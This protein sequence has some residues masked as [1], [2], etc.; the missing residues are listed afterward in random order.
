MYGL[1]GLFG[2]GVYSFCKDYTQVQYDQSVDK[3][4]SEKNPIFVEGGKEFYEK[5]VS[6]NIAL[7]KLMGRFGEKQYSALGNEN[8][9][10]R[11]KCLPLVTRKSFFEE[12]LKES[13]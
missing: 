12:K 5:S 6:R 11:Q 3:E 13:L 10:I 8:F 2:F 7:R 4:L 1:V 9:F